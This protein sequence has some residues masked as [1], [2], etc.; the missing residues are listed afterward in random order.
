MLSGADWFS[1]INTE[2]ALRPSLLMSLLRTF[3]TRWVV[4]ADPSRMS[5][6]PMPY[7][8]SEARRVILARRLRGTEPYTRFPDGGIGHTSESKRCWNRI[9]LQR[10]ACSHQV[11]ELALARPRDLLPSVRSRI[12]SFSS[13][14]SSGVGSAHRGC[15][16]LNTLRDFPDLA[17]FLKCCIWVGIELRLKSCL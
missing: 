16:Y 11:F 3:S 13:G 17:M 9:R 4:S 10:P 12:T 15:A 7:S 5:A 6:S 8:E 14:S 2:Y 1:F